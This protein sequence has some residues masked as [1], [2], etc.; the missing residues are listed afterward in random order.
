MNELTI[1][2]RELRH[3]FD[4]YMNRIKSGE[5]IIITKYGKPVAQ[6]MPARIVKKEQKQ[7]ASKAKKRRRE[8]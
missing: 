6:F 5:S 7:I 4:E 1:S 8:S 3:R 2:I